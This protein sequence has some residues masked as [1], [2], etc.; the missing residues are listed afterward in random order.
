MDFFYARNHPWHILAHE[1]CIPLNHI[2]TGV[3]TRRDI[4]HL[5]TAVS[6]RQDI[7]H[8]GTGISRR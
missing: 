3:L 5:G 4:R 1:V 8:L 6:W 7:S 2:G